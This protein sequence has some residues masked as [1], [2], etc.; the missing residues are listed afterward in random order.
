LEQHL[1]TAQQGVLFQILQNVTFFVKKVE[2]TESE[3]YLELFSGAF[4]MFSFF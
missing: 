1:K 4:S 2:K 3:G